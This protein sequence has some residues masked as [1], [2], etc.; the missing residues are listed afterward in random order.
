MPILLRAS[1]HHWPGNDFH[2]LN[3]LQNASKSL[4]YRPLI[5]NSLEKLLQ[6]IPTF[7]Q[8]QA[9]PYQFPLP[10]NGYFSSLPFH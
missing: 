6:G 3:L 8:V 4:R 10:L 5:M 9:K 1:E 2:F 7:T